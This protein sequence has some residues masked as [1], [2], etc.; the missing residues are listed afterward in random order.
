MDANEPSQDV[1]RERLERAAREQWGESRLEALKP[2]LQNL[3]RDLWLISQRP[4][5]RLDEVPD[6]FGAPLPA[7]GGEDHG[8]TL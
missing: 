2:G 1:L 3:A 4:L 5:D 6:L 7:A 8:A